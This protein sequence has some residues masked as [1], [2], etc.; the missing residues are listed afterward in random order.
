MFTEI[1]KMA[2]NLT[3]RPEPQ[4][5]VPVP[6]PVPVP[7]RVLVWAAEPLVRAG[8]RASLTGP[9]IEV[10]GEADGWDQI[11]ARLR[12]DT[13]VVLLEATGRAAEVAALAPRVGHRLVAM[14]D[15]A[16]RDS[17][18][19]LVR[20]GVRGFVS[21]RTAPADVGDA[22]RSVGRDAAYLSPELALHLLEWLC[23]RL[24]RQTVNVELPVGRLSR[25]EWEVL[26]ML[27]SGRSNSEISRN[28][29]IRETTVRSHVYHILTKLNLRT[30][31]EAVL[32]GFQHGLRSAD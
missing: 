20:S 3:M 24:S 10:Y 23:D 2:P 6:V 22:V 18:L 8:L 25:R 26:R 13:D 29:R 4:S 27:G 7:V 1:D 32:Y 17:F 30:R 14:V 16:D 19:T 9:D 21:S 12:S 15:A 28:L 11:P 5:S 31:T